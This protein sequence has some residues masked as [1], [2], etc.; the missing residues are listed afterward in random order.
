MFLLDAN[1]KPIEYVELVHGSTEHASRM[2]AGS[3]QMSCSDARRPNQRGE[4]LGALLES[5]AVIETNI[6]KA[7]ADLQEARRQFTEVI[8]AVAN[9]LPDAS[10]AANMRAFADGLATT[11]EQIETDYGLPQYRQDRLKA[12][13]DIGLARGT[14]TAQVTCQSLTPELARP[15]LA[16]RK[17]VV[18]KSRDLARQLDELRAQRDVRIA[19]L[20]LAKKAEP[21]A[22]VKD[23]AKK[24]DSEVKQALHTINSPIGDG[25]LGDSQFAYAVASVPEKEWRQDFNKAFARGRS[26]NVDIAIVL[27]EAADFSVKGMRFDATKVAQVASKV[28]TQSLLLAAGIAGVPVGKAGGSAAAAPAGASGGSTPISRR[29]SGACRFMRPT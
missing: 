1:R 3:H 18:T 7:T 2:S 14:E 6:A 12:N 23:A 20:Q 19:Q 24:S 29:R 22:I 17:V 10:Q 8:R 21:S 4:C 9:E 25:A 28:T 26:G 16:W 27:N 15:I 5:P 11:R 13:D